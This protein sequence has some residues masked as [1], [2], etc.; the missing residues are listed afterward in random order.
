MIYIL[1]FL[2]RTKLAMKQ[3]GHV[4]SP[5]PSLGRGH[6]VPLSLSLSLSLSISHSLSISTYSLYLSLYLYTLSFIRTA[7]SAIHMKKGSGAIR[8]TIPMKK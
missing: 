4:L 1:S 2:E 3:G 6:L 8:V 7:T 5:S